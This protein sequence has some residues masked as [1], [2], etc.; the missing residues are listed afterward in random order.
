MT[1]A[2][3]NEKIAKIKKAIDSP[4]TPEK[5]KETFKALLKKLEDA[6]DKLVDE[7]K[8]NPPK[9]K[10]VK[11]KAKVAPKSTEKSKKAYDC[12]ELLEQEKE[13]QKK[14]KEAAKARA[15]APVHTPATKNK[16]AIEKVAER[17]TKN[18]QK[19]IEKGEVKRPELEK[20]IKETESLLLHLKTALKQL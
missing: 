4:A 17:V 10:Q 9:E 12:D 14:R 16:I 20:L 18:V 5:E 11:E 8:V 19:R 15:E 1:K 3:Y 13:R 6:R 2:E 7:P